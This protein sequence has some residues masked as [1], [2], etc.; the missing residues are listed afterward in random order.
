MY[1]FVNINDEINIL[2]NIKNEDRIKRK[3]KIFGEHFCWKNKNICKIII[4]KQYYELKS[5]YNIEKENKEK[6]K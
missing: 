1:V 2:Y 3:I 6:L 4:D 5:Y